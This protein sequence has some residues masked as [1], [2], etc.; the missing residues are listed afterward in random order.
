MKIENSLLMYIINK[1]NRYMKT[2]KDALSLSY[3]T[4]EPSLIKIRIITYVILCYNDK[5]LAFN[6][7]APEPPAR[8]DP[9]PFYP[10]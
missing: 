5:N 4:K 7:F 9:D 6:P 8:A 10:L 3:R 1:T 2:N